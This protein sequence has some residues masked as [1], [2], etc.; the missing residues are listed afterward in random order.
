MR[1]P[2]VHVLVTGGAGS[3]GGAASRAWACRGGARQLLDGQCQDLVGVEAE[4]EICAATSVCTPPCGCEVVFHH[5]SSRC[6][7][8]GRRPSTAPVVSRATSRTSM[9]WWLR[10][11]GLRG[12]AAAGAGR[13]RRRRWSTA[14]GH[15]GDLNALTPRDFTYMQPSR[16]PTSIQAERSRAAHPRR[17]GA[18]VKTSRSRRGAKLRRAS[19]HGWRRRARLPC[20][21]CQRPRPAMSAAELT[22]NG[23]MLTAVSALYPSCRQN[24]W[25][26]PTEATVPV[27]RVDVPFSG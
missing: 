4:V 5:S 21:V 12:W 15:D 23:W 25:H 1:S 10:T 3:S 2:S 11:S 8:A 20:A 13:I 27:R 9:T 22:A 7:S 14:P 18:R 6:S 26:F 17:N 19:R 24:G 16:I